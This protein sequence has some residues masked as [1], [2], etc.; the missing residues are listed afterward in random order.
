MKHP[1]NPELINNSTNI[2]IGT[3]PPEGIDYYYSNSSKTRMWDILRSIQ[4]KLDYVPKNSYKLSIENK[5]LIL[6]K[7][8]LSMTDIIYEYERKNDTVK[9]IDIIP[10]KYNDIQN[11]VKET[12]IENYFF[13]YQSSLQWFL[14]SL[15]DEKPLMLNKLNKLKNVKYGKTLSIVV[16]SRTINCYLLPYPLNRGKKGETLEFKRNIY[17]K[18]LL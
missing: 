3:L 11:I 15:T 2:I 17:S 12:T 1:F 6:N 9:D 13:V 4:E 8:N 18:Y 10:I 5:K 16:D 14:H 7:L